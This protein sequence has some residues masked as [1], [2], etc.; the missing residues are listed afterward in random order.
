MSAALKLTGWVVS[1]TIINIE[2]SNTFAS[3]NRIIR[4]NSY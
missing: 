4:S 2:I 1:D 3:E